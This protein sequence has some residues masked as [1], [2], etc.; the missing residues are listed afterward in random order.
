MSRWM[1]FTTALAAE[2]RDRLERR[3]AIRRV[4]AALRP[5]PL[6]SAQLESR[7]GLG[8]RRVQRALAD[9]LHHKAIRRLEDR[10]G[11][12]GG[13]NVTYTLTRSLANVWRS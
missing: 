13:R 1:Q 7:T 6:T 11:K 5:D 3:H 10:A 12:Q 8:R 2:L 4:L 9:L